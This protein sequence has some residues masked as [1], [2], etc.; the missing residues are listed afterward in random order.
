[1]WN[2]RYTESLEIENYQSQ[3]VY[4]YVCKHT[5]VHVT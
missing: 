2:S 3:Y 4:M 5:W 1:M